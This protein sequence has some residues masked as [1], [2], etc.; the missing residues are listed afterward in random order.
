MQMFSVPSTLNAFPTICNCPRLL[1]NNKRLAIAYL[2]TSEKDLQE[3]KPLITNLQTLVRRYSDDHELV[4][5]ARGILNYVVNL[6]LK[7]MQPGL[8]DQAKVLWQIHSWVHWIPS[9]FVR[10]G[11]RDV[12]VLVI[13]SYYGA[14]M[15]SDGWARIQ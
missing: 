3:M 6:R 11:L 14:A 13:M 8:F 15:V 7:D 5:A 9:A 2:N 1:M 4:S 10:M 12:R